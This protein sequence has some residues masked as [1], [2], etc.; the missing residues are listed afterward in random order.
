MC[1]VDA[2]AAILD[3]VGTRIV[4]VHTHIWGEGSDAD[5]EQL[6]DMMD[7]FN[8]AWIGVSS[9]TGGEQPKPDEVRAA[10]KAVARFHRREPD[11]VVGFTYLNPRHG[12][13]ALDELQRCVGEHGFG[14]IKLW[15]SAKADD[16]CVFPVI[17]RAI[18]LGITVLQHSFCKATGLL[19]NESDPVNV[20]NLARRYPEARIIMAHM[21][22]DFTFGCDA[23]RDFPNVW[24]DMCGSYCETGMIDYALRTIGPERILFG[25][26]APGASFLNNLYKV[27]DTPLTPEQKRLIFHDNAEALKPCK[28]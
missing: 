17:E 3:E 6:V 15:V 18:D 8:L 5:S 13:D 7:R 24:A 9:L 11:R 10:N 4:D 26:D 28:R 20:A 21:G 2:A 27:L 16:P 23:I 22:A 19:E 1:T 25:T 14:F 12:P